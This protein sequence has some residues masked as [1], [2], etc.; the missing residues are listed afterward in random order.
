MKR[1]YKYVRIA[2]VSLQNSLAYPGNVLSGLGFYALFIYVFFCLWRAIY[3]GGLS[4]DFSLPQMVWYLCLTEVVAFGTRSTLFGQMNEDIKSGAIAYHMARPYHYVWYQFAYGLGQMALNL[5]MFGAAALAMGMLTVGPLPTFR[6]VHLPPMLLSLLLGTCLTFFV[7]LA[8]GLTAFYWEDNTGAFF[9]YSKLVF[10]LGTFLPL[11]FLPQWLQ[12][13]A[14][15]L[16]FSYVAWAPARLVVDFSWPMFW[17]LVPVQCL[18][19]V[20]A[21]FGAF[22]MFRLGA[23]RVSANGG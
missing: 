10:M 19:L 7:Q 14:R 21:G 17:Q 13:V 18:W 2:G 12:R 15:F 22:A 20:L 11:E 4:A 8:L 16:P 23:R 3:G 1:G 9:V 6:L 5:V